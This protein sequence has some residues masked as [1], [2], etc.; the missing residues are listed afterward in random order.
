MDIMD[1]IISFIGLYIVIGIIIAKIIFDEP[2]SRLP[3][4]PPPR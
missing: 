1:F 2:K 3:T 4:I